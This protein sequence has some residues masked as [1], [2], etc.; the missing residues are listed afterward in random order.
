MDGLL[1][2]LRGTGYYFNKMVFLSLK[3]IFVLAN[4]LDPDEMPHNAAIHLGL[5]CL[6]TC[7]LRS[8]PIKGLIFNKYSYLGV[9][10]PVHC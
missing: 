4:S 6:P 8:I 3:I 5:H 1:Y 7:T 9:F 10:T 2:I